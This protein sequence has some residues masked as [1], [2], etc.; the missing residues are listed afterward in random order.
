MTEKHMSIFNSDEN[1]VQNKMTWIIHDN[2]LVCNNVRETSNGNFRS[3]GEQ[4][5]PVTLFTF[6]NCVLIHTLKSVRMCEAKA[7]AN[8][9][10]SFV[11]LPYRTLFWKV[12]ND[13]RVFLQQN[14][15]K[16]RPPWRVV[17]RKKV[18]TQGQYC[19]FFW[20]FVTSKYL[21]DYQKN[22]RGHI[23]TVHYPETNRN[24]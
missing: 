19:K 15:L 1:I 16:R 21:M 12:F 10:W 14:S 4:W 13:S 7:L 20:W 2:S 9:C 24:L 23:Q 18:T 17:C 3:F 6:P 11:T 22:I 8:K 5:Y